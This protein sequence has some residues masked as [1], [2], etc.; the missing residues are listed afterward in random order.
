MRQKTILSYRTL[1]PGSLPNKIGWS[2]FEQELVSS[3]S[4]EVKQFLLYKSS[5]RRPIGYGLVAQNPTKS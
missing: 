5:K 3:S 4:A 1:I 2:T